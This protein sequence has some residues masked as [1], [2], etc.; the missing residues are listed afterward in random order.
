VGS[1]EA[2]GHP[3]IDGRLGEANNRRGGE[4]RHEF[5]RASVKRNGE[6]EE[7]PAS[8]HCSALIR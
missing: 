7:L 5:R 4:H 6:I 1:K 3:E 2:Y 8:P